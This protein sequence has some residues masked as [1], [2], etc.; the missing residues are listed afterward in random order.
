[1]QNTGT[2]T[3]NSLSNLTARINAQAEAERQALESQ[4]ETEFKTLCA[5]LRTSTA[6]AFSTIENDIQ[7]AAATMREK[8]AAQLKLLNIGFMERCLLCGLASLTL[9]AVVTMA[10]MG[11]AFVAKHYLMSLRQDLDELHNQKT[12]LEVTVQQL[13]SQTWGLTL[14]EDDNGRFIVPSPRTKLKT[15][16]K[17]GDRPA[18]KME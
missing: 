11:M 15:G 17:Y 3:S 18:I 12:T 16:W 8:T 14:I 9:L 5:N 10:G 13:Q 4:V 1:M 7:T 2:S 6:N